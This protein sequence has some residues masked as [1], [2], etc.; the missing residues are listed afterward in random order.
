MYNFSTKIKNH[1]ICYLV[2]HTHLFADTIY[3]V[4]SQVNDIQELKTYTRE[5]I[6]HKEE[7]KND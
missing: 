1:I 2:E 4:L 3:T 7:K 6:R 5:V